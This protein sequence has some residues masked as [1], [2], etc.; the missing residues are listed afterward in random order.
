MRHALVAGAFALFLAGSTVTAFAAQPATHSTNALSQSP[1]VA[2]WTT[3]L[4]VMDHQGKRH[5]TGAKD[6]RR[7]AHRILTRT[8]VL[9]TRLTHD[10]LRFLGVPFVFGG[11]TRAGF[12]CSG[13]VQHVFAKLGI[14]LP[15]TATQQFAVT[16]AV[17]TPR[18]GDLVFF[19]TYLPGPSHVGIYIGHGEFVSASDHGVMISHLSESYWASRYLGAKRVVASR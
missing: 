5:V 3:H 12:D 13:F 2:A 7:F 19:Q 15:R 4:V 8:S 16:Q 1:D 14:A 11:T 6:I 10:A 18:P 17:K 9:A